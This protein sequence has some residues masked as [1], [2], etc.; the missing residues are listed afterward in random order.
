[1]AM[2]EKAKARIAAAEKEKEDFFQAITYSSLCEKV[3][4]KIF[5]YAWEMGHSTSKEEVELFYNELTELVGD[6]IH[7]QAAAL[8]LED[9]YNKK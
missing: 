6:C 5:E 1:M 2:N 3:R 7:L 9:K 4:R 8:R